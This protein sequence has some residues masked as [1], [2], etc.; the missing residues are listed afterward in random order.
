MKSKRLVSVAVLAVLAS[1]AGGA[2]GQAPVTQERLVNADR[3]PGNWMSYGRDYA[4]QRFSPLKQ[5]DTQSV[6]KLG[7]AWSFDFDETEPVEATPIVVDGVMYVTSGWSK[8]FAMDAATGKELW[9]FDPEVDR[10]RLVWVCCYAVNRGVAVW[11][12]KVYV[13]TI[14]GDLIA[15]DAKTGKVVWK[16]PTVDRKEPYSITGAPRVAKGLVYI[17]NAGADIGVRGYVTAY[18]AETGKQVWR[19]YTVPGDPAKGFEDKAMEMAAKTWT[20]EWWKHGGGGTAWDSLVYDPEFDVL[21]IGVGNG[22]PWNRRVRSPDGGDNLFLASIVAVKATTGEYIWHYQVN[23]GESWDYSASMPMML[24]TLTIDGKPRKVLMQS[25]KNGFFY[26]IDRET[27]KLISAQKHAMATWASS[28]DLT[29]GRPIEAPDARYPDKAVMIYPSAA[30]AGNWQPMAFSPLTGLVYLQSRNNGQVY[31][32]HP[33]YKR[34]PLAINKAVGNRFTKFADG[35]PTEMPPAGQPGRFDSSI[36][37]WDPVQQK[38]VWRVPMLQGR[39][40]GLLATAGGLVFHGKG[41]GT[42]KA[43]DA[44]NGK[45]L[46]SYDVQNPAGAPPISYQVGNDQYIAV[47]LGWGYVNLVKGVVTHPNAYPNTNRVVAFKLGATHKLP[48]VEYTPPKLRAAPTIQVTDQAVDKGATLYDQF[49]SICHGGNGGGARVRPDLR[50]SDFLDNGDWNE[51]VLEGALATT[52]M[53]SFKGSLD[54]AGA[55]AIRSFVIRQAQ[56]KAR[57]DA[58]NLPHQ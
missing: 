44:T 43:Y 7:L 55:D 54:A 41:D 50:Y 6:N 33:N 27:G 10:S 21:Y 25:P 5:V 2:F 12:G 53:A 45:E 34:D 26:V 42:L 32:D 3:E 31:V 46:W 28:I 18:D 19:F 1:F 56:Q 14:D 17:G 13:G 58:P 4:E 39:G 47:A 37:A 24:A 30:G 20:G 38:D 51:V 23:P 11:N 49:C 36:A 9:R 48:P 57:E 15:L 35:R 29:T 52:G 16:T 22:A 40:A 8:V